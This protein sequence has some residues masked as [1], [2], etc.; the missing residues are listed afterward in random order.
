MTVSDIIISTLTGVVASF[1]VWW[2]TFKYLVPKINF[3]DKISKLQ[4]DENGSGFRY[5]I[6]FENS[7]NRNIIDLQVLIR[8]RIRGIRQEQPK[9]WEVVYLPTSSLEYKN[10]AIVRPAS[11]SGLRPVLEIKT[12]ECDYFQRTIFPDNIRILAQNNQLTLDQ[13]LNI[14]QEAEFQI[15]VLGY[16]EF[17]GARKFYE[18]KNYT[19]NDIAEGHFDL[20]SLN[21]Q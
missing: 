7:G 8:L 11:S 10:V 6:K 13:V 21:M 12:Y 1:F 9:N 15:M 18:S 2:L 14:G 16:D 3:A 4:T 17:S 5:R 20:N 19:I